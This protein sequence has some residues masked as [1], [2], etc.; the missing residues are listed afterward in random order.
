[1]T[2]FTTTAL[3]VLALTAAVAA[4]GSTTATGVSREMNPAISLNALFLGQWNDDTPTADENFVKLQEAEIQF[5]SVVDPFWTADVVV[6]FHPA[7]A[8]EGE[9]AHGLATDLEIAALQSTRLPAGTALTLGKFYVPFGKHSLLHTHQYPFTRAPIA[10]RSFLGDHGLTEVGAK[11]DYTVGLPWWSELSVAGVNGDA[12]IFD[13]ED[14]EPVW[15]AHWSNLWDVSDGGTL[16][17]GGSWLSGPAALHEG[18]AGGLDVWGAD[19]TW[20]WESV[21]RSHGPA[22]TVSAEIVAPDPEHGHGDPFGW[23]VNAQSRIHRNWWLGVGYGR[24]DDAHPLEHGHE[25][26]AKAE[27]E[28]LDW[29]EWKAALTY[30]PS[31][32]SALRL[33][34]AHLEAADG[35]PSDLRVSLQWNFTIGSHPAH[36][37]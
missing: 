12:E 24:A 25:E 22:A 30:A 6:S 4:A 18:E 3:A 29:T 37:Y 23:F 10:L 16:E 2:R 32:Y 27:D 11:L 35:G 14:R 7:H 36:L 8:H 9:E 21:T 34:A 20:R 26:E 19:L 31:E 33:E 28:L 5:S 13:A 17:L 15:A 1:M